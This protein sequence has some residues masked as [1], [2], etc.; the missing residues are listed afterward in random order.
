MGI[1]LWGERKGPVGGIAREVA[2]A[3][4]TVKDDPTIPVLAIRLEDDRDF[5]E[6]YIRLRYGG[7]EDRRQIDSCLQFYRNYK[8]CPVNLA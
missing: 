6:F 3:C 1:R 5:G 4:L 2:Q 7:K 8:P